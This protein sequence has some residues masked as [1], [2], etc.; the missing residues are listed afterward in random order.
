MS[1]LFGYVL[2]LADDALVA[3]QRMGEW[4]TNAPELEEDVALGNI[5]LDLLGQ[6]RSLLT[7]AGEVEGAGRDEDALAYFRD[8]RDFRN[9][10]LV[11]RERGDFA[12]AMARLL[13]LS[14]YQR[15]LYERLQHSG[16]ATLAAVAA[17]AVK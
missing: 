15:E 16:D 4:I 2:A 10:H 3:A 7:Y 14:T 13:F 17:K 8:E 6:A 11:E 5:A 12:V 9:V 1:D